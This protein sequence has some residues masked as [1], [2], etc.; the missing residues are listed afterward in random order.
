CELSKLLLILSLVFIVFSILFSSPGGL[1]AGISPKNG[2]QMV[3]SPFGSHNHLGDFL[4]LSLILSCFLMVKKNYQTSLVLILIIAPFYL[5]SFSRSAYTALSASLVIMLIRFV[6]DKLDFKVY[7]RGV[8]L[9]LIVISVAMFF[10][11]VKE[12]DQI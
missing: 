4:V 11:S 3:F 5:F 8:F 10:V 2:Y 6:M 12:A 1:L 7:Q 9:V